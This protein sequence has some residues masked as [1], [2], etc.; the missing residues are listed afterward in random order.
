MNLSCY[1]PMSSTDTNYMQPFFT[2]LLMSLSHPWSCAWGASPVSPLTRVFALG[3]DA[4]LLPRT[5]TPARLAASLVSSIMFHRRVQTSRVSSGTVR[6]GFGGGG[7]GPGASLAAECCALRPGD[8]HTLVPLRTP[9]AARRAAFTHS[10]HFV[11]RS[12]LHRFTSLDGLTWSVH[13]FW[14]DDFCGWHVYLNVTF[15]FPAWAYGRGTSSFVRLK[16]KILK[17]STFPFG[18][19]V[20]TK[21]AP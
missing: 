9:R 17:I 21:R 7:A 5:R 12:H 4:A 8:P 2:L 20:A 10:G 13:L 19:T 3:P 14:F 16:D 15:Q 1:K 18:G 11:N 6:G